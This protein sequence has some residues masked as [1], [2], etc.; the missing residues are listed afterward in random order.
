MILRYGITLSSA[1]E[2]NIKLLKNHPNERK[3]IN[4]QSREQRPAGRAAWPRLA[5]EIHVQ[6]FVLCNKS[7]R[8]LC[9][10]VIIQQHQIRR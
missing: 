6:F 4:L 10:I 7:L 1:K 2:K 8:I 5:F 9:R 3:K